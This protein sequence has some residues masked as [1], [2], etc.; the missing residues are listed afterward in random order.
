MNPRGFNIDELIE[1]GISFDIE[2]KTS[3]D[4]NIIQ[5]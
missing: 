2:T 1:H 4:F 5:I 3:K